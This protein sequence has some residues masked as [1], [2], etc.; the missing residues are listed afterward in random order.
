MSTGIYVLPGAVLF[1]IA[2][3]LFSRA[4]KTAPGAARTVQIAIAAIAFAGGLVLL[5]LGFR[6]LFAG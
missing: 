1:L 4:G 5:I 3:L 6:Q 2:S